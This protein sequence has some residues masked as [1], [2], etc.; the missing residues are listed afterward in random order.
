MS[1]RRGVSARHGLCFNTSNMISSHRRNNRGCAGL[2]LLGIAATL[3]CGD[4]GIGA[5]TVSP[6]PEPV[7]GT[8]VTVVVEQ[9]SIVPAAGGV[10]I[11]GAPGAVQRAK[12]RVHA[13]PLDS[14]APPVEAEIAPDA[15]FA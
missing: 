6:Q 10:S 11:V 7:P 13:I 1:D 2:V 14:T 9:V 3:G 12:G 8:P 4:P 15:S 5:Q